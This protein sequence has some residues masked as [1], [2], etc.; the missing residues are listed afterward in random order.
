MV[1][2]TNKKLIRNYIVD[3]EKYFGS[4]FEEYKLIISPLQFGGYGQEIIVND[5]LVPAIIIGWKDDFPQDSFD[6]VVYHEC[7]HNFVKKVISKHRDEIQNRHGKLV[8]KVPLTTRD[9]DWYDNFNEQ[10]THALSLRFIKNYYGK[11]YADAYARRDVQA[12]WNFTED[13]YY[14]LEKYEK[15]RDKYKNFDDFLPEIMNM[16]DTKL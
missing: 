8:D 4:H 15:N 5:T 16:L 7:I 2:L 10:L 1:E 14:L 6:Y 9:G 12:G 3:L 13:F 11:A